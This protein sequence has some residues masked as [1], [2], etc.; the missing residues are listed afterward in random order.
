MTMRS[1]KR[2]P[3]SGILFSGRFFQ[4]IIVPAMFKLRHQRFQHGD[5]NLRVATIEQVPIDANLTSDSQRATSP[6]IVHVMISNIRG[7]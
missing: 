5:R 6:E 3:L 2:D 1:E 7:N 4:I